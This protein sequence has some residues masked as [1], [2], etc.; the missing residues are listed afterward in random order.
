MRKP[1]SPRPTNSE[2]EI[3]RVI[4]TRGPSTVR[5]VHESLA[6]DRGVGYTTVLKL[7][8]IMTEKGLVRRESIRGRSHVYVPCLSQ[9]QTQRQ[10][11]RD[12]LE[13]AFGGSAMKLVLHA[14]DAKKTSSKERQQIRRL[15]DDMEKGGK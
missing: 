13:R 5:E 11:V 2:L 3:L 7:L 14:L 6:S 15:L 10:M 8:Q 1:A 9:D 4:W 12:L